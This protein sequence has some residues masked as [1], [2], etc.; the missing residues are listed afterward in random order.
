MGFYMMGVDRKIID[1]NLF[2][3]IPK[4]SNFSFSKLL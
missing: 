1:R 3:V 4:N 2:L